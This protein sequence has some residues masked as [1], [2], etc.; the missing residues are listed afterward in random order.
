MVWFEI[1]IKFQNETLNL[2][3]FYIVLKFY[4]YLTMI[5]SL[6]WYIGGN[7]Y[8]YKKVVKECIQNLIL[9]RKV[10]IWAH[11]NLFGFCFQ[12]WKWY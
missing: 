10:N 1:V 9:E 5:D 4:I 12:P 6:E 3:G 2:Q 7:K 8:I 11:V